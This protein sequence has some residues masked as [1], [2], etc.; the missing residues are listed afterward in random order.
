MKYAIVIPDCGADEPQ[1]SLG[2]RTALQAAH[3]PNMDRL[4][5]MGVVGWRNNVSQ[6]LT[7][8]SDVATLSPYR[9]TSDWCESPA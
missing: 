4:A 6:P 9:Q 8:A 1:S 5:R 2:G 7:P 3:L